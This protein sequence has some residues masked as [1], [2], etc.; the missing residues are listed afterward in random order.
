MQKLDANAVAFRLRLGRRDSP[1][2]HAAERGEMG[3]EDPL[4]LI[5]RQAAQELPAA[6]DTLEI[7]GAQLGQVGTVHVEA[8]NA[9]ACLEEQRQQT[10]GIQDLEGTRLDRRGPR[11][12]VGLNLVLD[13]PHGHAVASQVG[14]S[15]QPRGAG[16]DN[17]DFVFHPSWPCKAGC[18]RKAEFRMAPD[19][20]A[21]LE[22][23]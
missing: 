14:S 4:G 22:V 18:Y 17:Q 23:F 20:D 13:E 10:D 15:E 3:L 16:A 9:L 6:V 8:P 19:F 12:V 11:L 1:L 21:P 2:D 5:L 7:Q